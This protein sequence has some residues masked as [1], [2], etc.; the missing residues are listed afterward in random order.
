MPNMTYQYDKTDK[1]PN[2]SGSSRIRFYLLLIVITA[3][4]A[5]LFCWF[6]F[7]TKK[8]NAKEQ[9]KAEIKKEQNTEEMQKMD[10]QKAAS[11][12]LPEISEKNLPVVPAVPNEKLL[13]AGKGVLLPNDPP[14][15]LDKAQIPAQLPVSDEA[16]TALN[17]A[18]L[19]LKQKK[20][21]AAA[22]L[23]EKTAAAVQENTL[24]WRDLWK[25]VSAARNSLILDGAESAGVIRYNIRSGDSLSRL[26]D[27]SSTTVELLKKINHLPDN[28]LY[29]GRTLKILPGP[30]KIKIEKSARLLKLYRQEKLYLVFN[31]GIGR[32]GKTPSAEFAISYRLY[33]PDWYTT[34]GRLYPYGDPENQLGSCFLKLALFSSPGKP[35]SGF[36]IHGCK[37]ESSV[38]RSLSNGCIRL[39]NADV[40]LLYYLVPSGTRVDI[41]E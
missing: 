18:R 35:L 29:V 22:E 13:E 21:Q 10:P 1:T 17:K 32:M 3:L 4:L 27:R 31:A 26:A 23:A 11:Q 7:G 39:L 20:Y 40:E 2:G 12:D 38:G 34:D 25:I 5:G 33:H 28:R 9:S 16:K 8:G 41:T 15:E 19:L 36:G 6:F 14:Q 24:F 30:W 37:D